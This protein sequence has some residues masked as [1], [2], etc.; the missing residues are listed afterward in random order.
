MPES[1][2]LSG[3]LDGP[4]VNHEREARARE[5][6]KQGNACL[7]NGLVSTA[8]HWFRIADAIRKGTDA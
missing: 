6:E 1:S 2:S 8:R 4:R 3:R 5:A 7:A